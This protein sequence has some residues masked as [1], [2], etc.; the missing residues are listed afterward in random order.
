MAISWCGFM[1]RGKQSFGEIQ[2]EIVITALNRRS[3]KQ[4]PSHLNTLTS[5][6]WGG[7]G[8][9][10]GEIKKE[11]KKERKKEGKKERRI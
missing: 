1:I 3:Y 7:G 10:G 11:R 2:M 9:G 4:T 8:G 5:A 6:K